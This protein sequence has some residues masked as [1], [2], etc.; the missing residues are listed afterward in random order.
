MAG[1]SACPAPTP[2]S[3]VHGDPETTLRRFEIFYEGMKTFTAF[4]RRLNAQGNP[5][6]YSQH[7]QLLLAL[8][9]GGEEIRDVLTYTG[10]QDIENDAAEFTTV[11][12]ATLASLKANINETAAVHTLLV[13]TQDGETMSQYYQR[14]LKAARKIDWASYNA[15][16]AAKDVI[17]KGCT[18][19]RLRIKALQENPSLDDFIATAISMENAHNKSKAITKGREEEVR[20][21][22]TS[23]DNRMPS[24]SELR[25]LT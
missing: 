24:S 8:M 11:F 3:A 23:E 17:I 19:D 2:F 7:E 10:K 21:L 18:S 22:P 6:E 20:R 16:K 25:Y 1:A 5:V 12:E 9:I 13:M 14:I 4:N 15:E